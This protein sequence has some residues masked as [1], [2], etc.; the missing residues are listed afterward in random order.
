MTK[1]TSILLILALYAGSSRVIAEGPTSAQDKGG[2]VAVTSEAGTDQ[3]GRS[4]ALSASQLALWQ[5]ADLRSAQPIRPSVPAVL[6]KPPVPSIPIVPVPAGIASPI[7]TVPVGQAA[8]S[9]V[10][11]DRRS[12]ALSASQLALW[13]EENLRSAQPIRPSVPAVL[14]LK[15]PVKI[16]P[17]LSRPIVPVPAGIASPISTVPVGPTAPS[18]AVPV[19]KNPNPSVAVG[20]DRGTSVLP[21]KLASWQENSG[22]VQPTQPIGPILLPPKPTVETLPVPNEPIM[23]I[24]AGPASPISTVPAGPA[25]PS[26]AVPARGLN[27]AADEKV[28]PLKDNGSAIPFNIMDPKRETELT[29]VKGR[30]QLLRSTLEFTRTAVVDPNVCDLFQYSTTEI[31]FIGKALGTTQVTV[32]FRESN[33]PN[34]DSQPRSF[35]VHVVPDT[36]DKEPRLKQLE[37]ELAKLFPNSKVRLRTFGQRI[38]VLGQARDVA[39]AAEILNFIRGEQIDAAGKWVSGPGQAERN[40]PGT[41]EGAGGGGS[42]GRGYNNSRGRWNNNNQYDWSDRV[43]NMLKVPGVHQVMLRV[44]IAELNRTAGRSFSANF[45]TSIQF[46]NGSL[47]LQSL[48]SASSG[49][50]IIGKFDN[51]KLNFGI[52]YL[53]EHGVIRLLSEPTLVALS[54]QSANFVAGGEFAVPTVVGVGG[55]SAVT[56]DFRAYGAIVSFTPYVLDKDLIRLDVSPEFSQIGGQSVGGTPG[57][58]TRAVHTTVELRAG[59]TLAIAGLLD[60]SMKSDT[61]SDWPWIGKLLGPRNVSRAETELIVLV[62]PELVQPME[63]EEVPPMPG[64]DV[65]EPDNVRF[66]LGGEIEGNPTKDYRSTVWPRLQQ[67]YRA[68]GSPMISGPFGHSTPWAGDPSN[69]QN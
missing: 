61:A 35:V 16:P 45:S 18:A 55:A 15:P 48:L 50:S 26:A 24:P 49:N 44:K 7:P 64:F 10:G 34:V 52:H 9:A 67:R 51:D 32:W 54:G 14:L 22:G 59:Q 23:P 3:N 1:I 39:E 40:D 58:T 38:I 63:P 56:T 6:L 60:E 65:T 21:A 36:A 62:T 66:F 33:D 37:A 43:M 27:S 57:L 4:F 28:A 25:A 17:V 30:S 68:G 13:Q 12:F 8:P 11:E 2:R 19:R 42:Q 53:E 69:S 20:K 41:N 31:G 5:E 29:V 46:R 47:L